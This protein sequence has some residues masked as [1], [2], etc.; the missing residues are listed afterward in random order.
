M[1]KLLENLG[2]L[3]DLAQI[4]GVVGI[5]LGIFLF[6]TLAILIT[7]GNITRNKLILFLVI[8]ICSWSLAI[9]TIII[10]PEIENKI[11]KSTPNKILLARTITTESKVSHNESILFS[12]QMD[13]N[14]V[15]HTNG[16]GRI[17]GGIKQM[18]LWWYDKS[19]LWRIGPWLHINFEIKDLNAF[20]GVN[21][22]LKHIGSG[23]FNERT[24]ADIII[25]EKLYKSGFT[26]PVESI[27]QWQKFSLDK[28]LLKNGNNIITLRLT[29]D[30]D[31]FV[32][33]IKSVKITGY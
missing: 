2:L 25:N 7:R 29:P 14:S 26:V 10:K 11:N 23:G 20:N 16:F 32:W 5:S 18:P 31:K 13:K 33:W 3:K 15:E 21:L 30:Y 12:I 27:E 17:D 28:N 6:I 9:I 1:D 4:G 19:Y 8:I 22:Y 24:V